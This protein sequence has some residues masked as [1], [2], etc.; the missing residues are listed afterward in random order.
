VREDGQNPDGR[1]QKHN[2]FGLLHESEPGVME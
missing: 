2:N 1:Q